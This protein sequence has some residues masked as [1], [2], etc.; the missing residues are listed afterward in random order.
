MALRRPRSPIAILGGIL[1]LDSGW[2]NPTLGQSLRD[3]LAEASE[4]EELDIG[5]A[6]SCGLFTRD[7]DGLT[8]ALGGKPATAFLLELTSLLQTVAT[9]GMMGVGAY[10]RW[11]CNMPSFQADDIF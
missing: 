6:A 2:S 1:A 7:A 4:F 8:I 9:V 5:C 11:L 10:A 3:V